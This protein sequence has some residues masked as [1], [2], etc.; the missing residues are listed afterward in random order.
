MNSLQY[1][2]LDAFTGE[3]RQDFMTL[4]KSTCGIDY[5]FSKVQSI[6]HRLKYMETQHL[7]RSSI[8]EVEALKPSEDFLLVK[9]TT[10]CSLR[11]LSGSQSPT[12][13]SHKEKRAC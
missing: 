10:S 6:L 9:P 13:V 5:H 2:P 11:S 8:D 1:V 7:S 4:I 12:C 3:H